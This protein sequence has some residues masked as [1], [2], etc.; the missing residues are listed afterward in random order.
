[1]ITSD[2]DIPKLLGT[3]TKQVEWAK[4][5]VAEHLCSTAKRVYNPPMQG[6]FSKTL[7]ITLADDCETVIQFRTERLDINGFLT[8]KG[9]LN[10]YVLGR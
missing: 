2:K 7:F 5:P 3:P 4:K 6:L 1:M 10:A 9:E 8:A